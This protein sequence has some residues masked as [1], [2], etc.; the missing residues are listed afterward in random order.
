MR[1]LMER[2]G[3]CIT[4]RADTTA[5]E[6]LVGVVLENLR[7]RATER[8]QGVVLTVSGDQT[9][10]QLIDHAS[11][12][13]RAP[14]TAGGL[15]Y[16]LTD[17]IVHHVANEANKHHC[18]HAGAVSHA[19]RALV[20]PAASG[21][22]KSFLTLWLVSQGFEY[23]TDEMVLIDDASG[24]DGI[25]RPIQI[26]TRGLQAVD[27]LIDSLENIYEGIQS[28]AVPVSCLRGR[29]T[30]LERH[31][32]GII[33][34]PEFKPGAGYSF[35]RLSASTA[36]LK[37]MGNHINARNLVG[38]GFS[39]VMELVRASPCY[40]LEYGG[41]DS[42]PVNFGSQLRRLLQQN[43]SASRDNPLNRPD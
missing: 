32:L 31:E 5:A 1:W 25:A 17:R 7:T 28:N 34:F 2:A 35:S 18:L 33:L 23:I 24:I 38:H 36:G 15:I 4:V 29:V 43:G 42:L 13:T 11:G 30:A 10:W 12:M 16:Q 20:M 19:G 8:D 22:G 39:S 3:V 40:A 14:K 27:S 21:C 9:E 6:Q 37:I 26:K 41:F